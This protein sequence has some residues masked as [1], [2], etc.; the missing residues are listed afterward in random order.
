MEKH[1]RWSKIGRFFCVRFVY[2]GSLVRCKK[3]PHLWRLSLLRSV[4][5]RLL[6][7]ACRW[8]KNE[9]MSMWRKQCHQHVG[10][11]MNTWTHA[12]ITQ[13]LTLTS[14][15]THHTHHTHITPQTHASTQ[16]TVSTK[17]PARTTH[18]HDTKTT[19]NDNHFHSHAHT[20]NTHT[21]TS[22]ATQCERQREWQRT[23][24]SEC[25]GLGPFPVCRITRVMP[26][27][28][29]VC[30]VQALCHFEW[31]GPVKM[32]KML[33]KKK[34]TFCDQKKGASWSQKE[35]FHQK[36]GPTMTKKCHFWPLFFLIKRPLF[37]IKN[38]V[39]AF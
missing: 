6:R 34:G 14:H 10:T 30:P 18:K 37:L 20:T 4:G 26:V 28:I 39:L 23:G 2:G 19:N 11:H 32:G 12:H 22:P 13:S 1:C 9:K 7:T 31:S 5:I 3:K 38:V 29:Q 27:I 35:P 15:L 25:M 24:G 33:M 36:K 8:Q 21:T 17:E 16:N